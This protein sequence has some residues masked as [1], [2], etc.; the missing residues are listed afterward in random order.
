[1]GRTC[2]DVTWQK[3]T[4]K[5]QPKRR[6]DGL[7]KGREVEKSKSRLSYLAWNP[8]D[9][10]GFPLSHSPDGCWR[11]TTPDISLATRTGHFDLLRT[12]RCTKAA[13]V[14]MSK[15]NQNDGLATHSRSVPKTSLSGTPRLRE[16]DTE[17]SSVRMC[18]S[19]IGFGR[20]PF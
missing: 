15:T 19:K 7:W 8:A 1:M 10:A 2:W 11:L 20:A 6:R 13:T 5:A 3:V 12:Y 14:A 4:C 9:P 18:R 17:K 16:R